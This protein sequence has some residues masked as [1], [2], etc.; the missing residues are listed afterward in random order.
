MAI[1]L[2]QSS[3]SVQAALFDEMKK[4]FDKFSHSNNG[5][6]DVE[7][8]SKEVAAFSGELMVRLLC[9]ARW[10]A[11]LGPINRDFPE[12]LRAKISGVALS[13]AKPLA[14][15]GS[16]AMR[17]ELSQ[18]LAQ[19]LETER[20]GPIRDELIRAVALLRQ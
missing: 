19:W 14:L 12:T 3:K 6:V 4:F 2:A 11:R 9:P 1:L 15:A 17:L 8:I 10:S 18:A 16:P 7:G 20:S 13:F 5:L